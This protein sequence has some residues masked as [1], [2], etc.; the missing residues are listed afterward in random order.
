L[1][2][3]SS[4]FKEFIAAEDWDSVFAEIDRDHT[5]GGENKIDYPEFW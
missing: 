4:I 3:E 2:Q 5:G 1:V